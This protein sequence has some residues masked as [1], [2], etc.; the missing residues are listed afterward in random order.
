MNDAIIEWGI[1]LMPS[2][3]L[4]IWR[5]IKEC[6]DAPFRVSR[7]RKE[8]RDAAFR[9][10]ILFVILGVFWYFGA[11]TITLLGVAVIAYFIVNLML[12]S[13]CYKRKKIIIEFKK[14]MKLKQLKDRECAIYQK[15][16]TEWEEKLF[17]E[18]QT[19]SQEWLEQWDEGVKQWER[20][21]LEIKNLEQVSDVRGQQ[22][23]IIKGI[24]EK[25]HEDALSLY[26]KALKEELTSGHCEKIS[27]NV[28]SLM[29]IDNVKK[30]YLKTVQLMK[31]NGIIDE[32]FADS[33]TVDPSTK[34]TKYKPTM[35][36]LHWWL[37]VLDDMIA[38]WKKEQQ[39]EF[40]GVCE[41]KESVR[42]YEDNIYANAEY[43]EI[44]KILERPNSLSH[45]YEL[46]LYNK[47]S[48]LWLLY[49]IS[50]NYKAARD[51]FLYYHKLIE[52]VK[53]GYMAFDKDCCYSVVKSEIDACKEEDKKR[54][55][56]LFI[57]G[58]MLTFEEAYKLGVIEWMKVSN[59]KFYNQRIFW[60]KLIQIENT[61]SK[62]PII[63]GDE[64]VKVLEKAI[65]EE[66]EF[67]DIKLREAFSGNKDFHYNQSCAHFIGYWKNI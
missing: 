57:V 37:Y 41:K 45:D 34:E 50:N 11:S 65:N 62:L 3:I 19:I 1:R 32:E 6:W 23:S 28:N 4:F 21:V 22:H 15:I 5:K 42:I 29:G 18:T 14:C 25:G 58:G 9:V 13:D 64:K 38:I 49:D 61:R 31:D 56:G 47:K 46:L 51:T 7:K 12:V 54:K 59:E 17:Q 30:S 24:C 48:I 53:E 40:E 43:E 66:K 55:K 52:T 63:F 36:V 20:G 35:L 2:I 67:F 60:N 44:E 16:I 39:E 8:C 33:L 10:L 26:K 27:E